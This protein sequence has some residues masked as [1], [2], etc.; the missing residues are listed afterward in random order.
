MLNVNTPAP[1]TPLI[2]LPVINTAKTL[3]NE[4]ISAPNAKKNDATRIIIPGEKIM[5]NRPTRGAMDAVVMR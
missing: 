3:A 5:A 2:T 4:H 1:P